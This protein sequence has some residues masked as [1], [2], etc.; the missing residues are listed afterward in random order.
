VQEL[1]KSGVKASEI[2]VLFRYGRHYEAVELEL[3]TSG[4]GFL[5]YGGV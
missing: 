5:K 1:L 2:A 4:I 3:S